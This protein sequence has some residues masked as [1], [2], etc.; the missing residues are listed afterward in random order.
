MDSIFDA[1][2]IHLKDIVFSYA[3]LRICICVIIKI[4]RKQINQI[5]VYQI[6]RFITA[7]CFCHHRLIT[8]NAEQSPMRKAFQHIGF[9]FLIT[10]SSLTPAFF[11]TAFI[12]VHTII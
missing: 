4:S 2:P 11:I 5:F 7:P 10:D 8:E 1:H 6:V 3:P 12:T 9:S